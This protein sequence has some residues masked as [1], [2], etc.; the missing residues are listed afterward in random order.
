MKIK[1]I[2]IVGYGSHTQKTL[3]PSFQKILKNKDIKL[4]SSKNIFVPFEIFINITQAIKSL[5]KD[6]FFYN[7][8]P[9]ND[10]YKTSKLILENNFNLIVEKPI[11][12]NKYQLNNLIQ[13]A[14]RKNRLLIENM[15]YFQTSQ[16]S[17]FNNIFSGLKSY[18]SLIIN[19]NLPSFSHDS[20]RIKKDQRHS[21]LLYDV[22]CY[23]LSL[24]SHLK[25]SLTNVYVTAKFRNNYLSSVNISLLYKKKL[26]KINVGFFKKYKNNVK[27]VLTNN[28]YIE[29]EHFFYGKKLNKKINILTKSTLLKENL[30]D[31]NAFEKLLS[32]EN[33]YLLDLS[34]QSQSIAND[35]LYKLNKIKKI[36][37]K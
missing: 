32:L 8:S 34:K 12:L 33:L 14:K 9:P 3:L 28:S 13:I 25:I 23:P 31:I 15:M 24:L 22:L 5:S 7:S 17:Y 36:I 29:F 1:K 4:V 16:F 20:F 18:K 37:Y 10:H 26:I 11:C 6:F 19:F 30:F 2:C 27:L 35:Y 21:L